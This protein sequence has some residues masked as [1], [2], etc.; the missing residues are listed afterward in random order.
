MP[1][2]DVTTHGQGTGG[3]RDR[4]GFGRR[5]A[6]Q[7]W[8]SRFGR[9]VD[10]PFP[11]LDEIKIRC[12][13]D[14]AATGRL[15]RDGAF[16]DRHTAAFLRHYLRPG[17]AVADI[18]AN[19]GLVTM[20]M[21]ALVG[22]GGRVDAFEPS[23]QMRR[24]L[25]ENLSL[26]RL[27]Q[28]AVQSRMAGRQTRQARFADA[29]TKS[30]RRRPPL[31]VELATGVIGVDCVRLDEALAGRRYSLLRIDVAGQ[32][33]A[34]LEGALRML[35]EANPPALLVALDEALAGR[36]YSLLR[37]DVAGQEVAVLEGALRMLR[38]A[39]PPALLVALDEAL[40]DYGL[41][42][43]AAIEWLDEHDYEVALYNA[44][45][46]R[47]D[48]GAAPWQ[49]SRT[50]IALARAARNLVSRRLAGYDDGKIADDLHHHAD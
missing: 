22:F 41:S 10:L 19:V 6:W 21:A 5:A 17:D 37:I 27:I 28:V 23:S 3:R 15:M 39:N 14:C 38:E 40:A 13:P 4:G 32:E 45:Q 9:T 11:G 30:G 35:R 1:K 18:G 24:R 36:R 29:T 8:H 49:R 7:L 20:Q 33:V 42:P 26:N 12:F 34:V 44:D 25:S 46:H 43:E 47:I 16:P 2:P 31:P 50:V 48:Y